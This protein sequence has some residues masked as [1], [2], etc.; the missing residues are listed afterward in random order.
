MRIAEINKD[1]PVALYDQVG[2][3]I[4]RAIADGEVAQGERLPTAIDLAVL[5]VNK[6]TVTRALHVLRDEG[7]LDFT[8]GT[9]RASGSAA[10]ASSTTPALRRRRVPTKEGFMNYL[11]EDWEPTGNLACASAPALQSMMRDRALQPRRR[12]AHLLESI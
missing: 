9:R 10:T 6:K 7:P 11:L 2:A 8:R 1:E 4:R 5:R 12:R 3:E